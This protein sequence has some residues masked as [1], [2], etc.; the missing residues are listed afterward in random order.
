[1]AK[2]LLAILPYM[3]VTAAVVGMTL[4]LGAAGGL[5]LLRCRMS[6]CRPVRWMAE[7]VIAIMR[8]TPSIV[9]LFIVFYGVPK[10]AMVWFGIDINFAPKIVFVVIA[11]SLLYA[12]NIAEI[13]RASYIAVGSAQYEA[14][15][16]AG[17]TARQA[18]IR[19][20]GPQALAAAL[21]N[22]CNSLVALLK[23]GSLAYTI[24]LIDM[25]GKGN[26]IISCNYGARA[27]E[28]YIA[29]AA[30]YCSL[31]AIIEKGG[32]LLEARLGRGD[33]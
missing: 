32:A 8:C 28:T 31:T 14:A 33:T 20:V 6:R 1:M 7:S 23:E 18:I 30:V 16:C 3:G 21:P 4:L 10:A 2:A 25:M 12:A 22:L 13:F 9:M 24:G 27:L 26:L 29:L 11:L 17:L 5:L 15:L 19:I